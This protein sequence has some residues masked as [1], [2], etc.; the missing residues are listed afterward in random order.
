MAQ[1][2]QADEYISLARLAAGERFLQALISLVQPR[3]L[4]GPLGPRRASPR[5]YGVTVTR[6]NVAGIDVVLVASRSCSGWRTTPRVPC[7]ARPRPLFPAA[8]NAFIVGP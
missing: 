8:S 2:H 7:R 6:R 5:S 3:K 4:L 1:A